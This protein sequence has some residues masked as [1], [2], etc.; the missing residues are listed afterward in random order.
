MASSTPGVKPAEGRQAKAL[1]MSL[2]PSERAELEEFVQLTQ[3][4]P[5]TLYRNLVAPKVRAAIW[6]LHEMIESGMEIDSTKIT[7]TIWS[8]NIDNEEL[9]DLYSGKKSV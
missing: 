3:V 7:E 2:M 6:A 5:T 1:S 4:G 9:T 8:T